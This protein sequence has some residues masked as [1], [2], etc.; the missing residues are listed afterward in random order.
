MML[1]HNEKDRLA[2]LIPEYEKRS[3]PLF[4]DKTF[5]FQSLRFLEIDPV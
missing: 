5:L 2:K 1:G 4:M 3:C